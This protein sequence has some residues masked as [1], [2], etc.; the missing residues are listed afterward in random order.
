MTRPI[1]IDHDVSTENIVSLLRRQVE[2]GSNLH[3]DSREI[4]P[5]DIFVAC[6][7]LAGDGRA[8]IQ[9]AISK[10]ASAVLIHSEGFTGLHADLPVQAFCISALSSRLGAIAHEWY[11]R[12]SSAVEVIAVTGTNGKTSCAFWLTQ[13]FQYL[14]AKAGS[15]GTLGI[16]YP[17]GSCDKSELTT[18]D[19]VSMHRHLAKL[20]DAGARF[21]V[22]EASSIG[23]EQ[24]RLDSVRIQTAAYTNLS[25][26][27]LDYHKTMQAYEQA[28]A[29]LFA[30]PDLKHRVINL[31][32][33]AGRRLYARYAQSAISYGFEQSDVQA[34]FS[35][36]DVNVEDEGLTFNAC[37]GMDKIVVRTRLLG[38]HNVSN[39]LCVSAV[40]GANG[41]QLAQIVQAL[42][43][44]RPVD[45]RLQQVVPVVPDAQA[46]LVVVDYSHTPDA[47]ERAL[48]ALRPLAT[49][50]QGR[51]WCVVGCGGQRDAGKRPLMAAIAQRLAEHVV[52]T[53]DNP[54]GERPQDIIDAMMSGVT[55]GLS[56]IKTE[57]DRAQAILHALFEAKINDVIL[58]AGK[59][60]ETYQEIAGVK[61][62]FD[63]RHWA[64][65]GLLLRQGAKIQTDSRKLEPGEVFLAL[66]GETFDGH[67]YLAQV[68]QSGAI[69]AIV[70]HDNSAVTIPQVVLGDTRLAL[71]Q[72]GRAWR[73][74][75]DIPV[76]A[77]AGSNGKTTTKEMI[78]AIFAAWKGENHRLATAGNLNNELGVPLTL[79]RLN[80]T[81]RAAVIEMG[82]NHPGEIEVL[83][84]AAEP[85]VALVN[86]AQREHQEFMVSVEAVAQ[87][88]GQVFHHLTPAGVA[89][90]PADDAFAGIW[91]R[92]SGTHRQVR[93]GLNADAE[94][95]A[96]DVRSDALGSIF[97]L[98]TPLGNAE[99]SLPVPGVHNVR[100]ALAATASSIAAGVPLSDIIAGLSTFKAVGGRMQPHRLPGDVVLID[101]TYNANPDSVRA[102]IDVLA[103]LPAPRVLVLGDMGEVGDHGPEMHREVGAY[104]RQKGVEILLTLGDATRESALAFGERAMAFEQIEPLQAEL[105]KIDA[106]SFLIKGSRFMKMERVV[107]GCLERFGTSPGK[108]VSHAV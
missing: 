28:K 61:H 41:W 66:R 26:D 96:D 70:D 78:A 90:Y 74:R 91:S 18:P 53:S 89:V 51:I 31:D 55:A 23:L 56:N 45:G 33:D 38:Q 94:V 83:A 57:V 62:A 106:R 13:A 102:A 54:R 68:A 69:A 73:R 12:P 60:H 75:F 67:D 101:D 25:R 19:V 27:H 39:L 15:I 17:D 71:L 5:G 63:D 100:N 97:A 8:Y 10:G 80:E 105:E 36:T 48:E 72:L 58:V 37:Q 79:L 21:A 99:L 107:R 81:H 108:L 11:G 88:N 86:N 47:L 24:G 14:G 32:D 87:E 59:G 20:R 9:Q 2:C 43:M 103:S 95:W 35:A 50:R 85:T 3:I 64:Q 104:A 84:I 7:G 82:M 49:K 6:P 22:I 65:A 16:H 93:F 29:K 44:L 34:D 46:P 30:W 52:I 4:E 92:M 76:A 98:H 1:V 40:L 42:E 77:V